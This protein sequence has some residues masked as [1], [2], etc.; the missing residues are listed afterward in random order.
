ML[1]Q[2]SNLS[3]RSATVE[4]SQILTRWW[5]D[6]AVMEHA[7][8]PNGLGISQDEVKSSISLN[9]NNLSQ[10]CIIE[11]DKIRIGECSF[12]IKENSAAIGIKICDFSYQNRKLGSEI[13]KMLIN[14][15]KSG[16]KH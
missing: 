4:D 14:Y 11:F 9:K 12:K 8:F 10:R 2:K 15:L 13:L 5:N 3:I 7:G 1:I 6:G 16:N